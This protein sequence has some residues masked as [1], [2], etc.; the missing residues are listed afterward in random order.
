VESVAVDPP[1]P[2]RNAAE[3]KRYSGQTIGVYSL[4]RADV[5]E[6]AIARRFTQD[7]GI[8]AQVLH[9]PMSVAASSTDRFDFFRRVL[10]AQSPDIDVLLM[11]ITWPGALAPHLVDLNPKL[12]AEARQH[13]PAIIQNN[14]VNGRLIGM[15]ERGDFGMLYY[16]KDLVQ[17]YGFSSPPSTWKELEQQALRI[18][19]GERAGNP[20]FDG[21]VYQGNTNEGLTCDALEWLASSGG[22]AIVEN[23]QVTV[24]NPRAV[25]ILNQMRSWIGSVAPRG[26]TNYGEEDSRKVFQSGNAAFMR[27]WP[28][29]Y[30]LTDSADSPVKGKFDV[31]PLPASPGYMSVA[32]VGGWEW[33]VSRYSRAVDAAIEWVRYATSPEVQAYR[34]VQSALVPTIPAVSALPEVLQAEPFLSRLQDVARVTRPSGVFGEHYNEASTVFFEGVNQILNGQDAGVVLVD[35]QRQLERLLSVS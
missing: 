10:Q 18:V 2:V 1:P 6:D 28:Y 20:T 35:V 5:F 25:A 15:P 22:G 14:T 26:V 9:S 33:A 24:N 11:D 13:Y 8:K 31:A 3:A 17:K 21:F 19:D 29:V 7:T 23:H 4:N 34:A 16:R 27:N 12:S 32:T 30:A